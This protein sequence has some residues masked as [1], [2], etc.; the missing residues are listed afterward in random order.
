MRCPFCSDLDNR[1]IDSRMARDGRAIRR[2]RH[3]GAC[4]QRFTTYE[5]V[6]HTLVEVTKKDGTS[7]PFDRDK[8]VRSLSIA[9][10]KRP[11]PVQ[12]LADWAHELEALLMATPRKAVPSVELGDK[13]MAFLQHTDPVAYVR[14]ASVY[15][16]FDSVGEFLETIQGFDVHEDGNG[17]APRQDARDEAHPAP[18]EA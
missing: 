6:E 4:N 10:R 2:R 1:V 17:D 3:C 8:L 12:Q 18:S 16:S 13:I 15:K 11:I 14:Y 5:E 7:E 9:C